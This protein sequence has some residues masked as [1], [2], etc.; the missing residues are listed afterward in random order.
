MHFNSWTIGSGRQK[1]LMIIDDAAIGRLKADNSIEAK[2][3]NDLQNNLMPESAYKIPFSY[4][5]KI[6]HREGSNVINVHFG[7]DAREEFRVDEEAVCYEILQILKK[8]PC[9][10]D[11]RFDRYSLFRAIKRP[12]IAA[13][14]L[15]AL[16]G[17]AFLVA[18]DLEMGGSN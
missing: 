10:T 11:Y 16:F 1:Y 9:C 12:L 3:Y 8:H 18:K 15:T 17:W 4:V 2:V 14:I 5:R 7:K 6:I 13:L